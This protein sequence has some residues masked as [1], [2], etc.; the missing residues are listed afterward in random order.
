ME[1]FRQHIGKY[2]F[3]Y[4]LLA[5]AIGVTIGTNW[6]TIK[7]WFSSSKSASRVITGDYIKLLK[8]A[9]Q[10]VPA[11]YTQ[12]CTVGQYNIYAKNCS[13]NAVQK[14]CGSL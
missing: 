14:L 10:D 5:L 9:R 3:L 8:S 4:L 6:D 11:G 1:K 13:N 12:C 7:G 2:A